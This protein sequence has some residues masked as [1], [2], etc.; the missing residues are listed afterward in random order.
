ME[1]RTLVIKLTENQFKTLGSLIDRVNLNA[2]EVPAFNDLITR[3]EA[4]EEDG[5]SPQIQGNPG[6]S[7][8][9][10]ALSS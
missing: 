10:E 4:A 3:L 8:N 2:K 1:E 9:S 7:F 5:A 6:A